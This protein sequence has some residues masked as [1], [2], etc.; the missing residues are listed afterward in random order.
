MLDMDQYE[1]MRSYMSA[2]NALQV[3]MPTDVGKTRLTIATGS[4]FGET[5]KAF[6]FAHMFD[7]DEKPV[8]SAGYSRSGRETVWQLGVSWEF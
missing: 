5:A 7:S 8:V 6:G 4:A 1:E 3:H 2:V